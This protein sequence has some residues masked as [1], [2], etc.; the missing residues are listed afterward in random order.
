MDHDEKHTGVFA[1]ALHPSLRPRTARSAPYALLE[2]T[3]PL[4]PPYDQRPGLTPVWPTAPSPR[5][6]PR[7]PYPCLSTR[8]A[9]GGGM[10]VV[11]VAHERHGTHPGCESSRALGVVRGRTVDDARLGAAR[12]SVRWLDELIGELILARGPGCACRNRRARPLSLLR[13]SQSIVP[14]IRTTASTNTTATAASSSRTL[15]E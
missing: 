5:W 1:A 11:G 4:H 13:D 12:L 15:V 7:A 2:G 14:G 3:P 6:S 8:A 9:I 10:W